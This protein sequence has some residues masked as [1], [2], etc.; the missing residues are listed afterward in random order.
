ME[1]WKASMILT[2]VDSFAPSGFGAIV[3]SDPNRRTSSS[4]TIRT[5]GI[6]ASRGKRLCRLSKKMALSRFFLPLDS[7]CQKSIPSWMEIFLSFALSAAIANWTFSENIF[8]YRNLSS[9]TMSVQRSSL[10]YS[11]FRSIGEMNWL[12]FFLT[13]YP[14]RFSQIPNSVNDV[15]THDKPIFGLTMF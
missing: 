3:N 13:S 11:R 14:I 8:R 7:S 12:P 5:T 4:F 10:N 9:I 6:A 15:L 2:T 1:P